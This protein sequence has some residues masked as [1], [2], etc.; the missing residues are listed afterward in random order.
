MRLQLRWVVIRPEPQIGG[1]R[2]RVH[3]LTGI[4]HARGV[5]DRLEF[6]KGFDQFRPV[7]LDQQLGL[8]LAVTMLAGNRA[9]VGDNEIGS[10]VEETEPLPHAI[11]R[12]Q[13]EIDP[14]MDAAVAEMAVE[15]G[16]VIV[17]FE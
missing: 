8:G 17:G 4:H 15:R 6:A 9:T 12:A 3:D 16:I 5:P 13:A 11:L 10:L 14:A 2:I 7:H 1:D